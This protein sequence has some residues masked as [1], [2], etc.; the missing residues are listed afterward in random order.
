MSWPTPGAS[1]RS[2]RGPTPAS[3]AGSAPSTPRPSRRRPRWEWPIRDLL[4]DRGW[5]SAWLLHQ[6]LGRRLCHHYVASRVK[7]LDVSGYPDL[8][9]FLFPPVRDP[10]GRVL[11]EWSS[12]YYPEHAPRE[13]ETG[14]AAAGRL[15]EAAAPPGRPVVWEPV[16][17]HVAA[18]L[19]ALELTATPGADPGHRIRTEEDLTGSWF[20]TLR[21]LAGT[22]AAELPEALT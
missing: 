8:L 20:R 21:R 12:P 10:S 11:A 4:A 13:W 18:A 5:W 15:I 3:A 6:L 19:S 7:A 9:A 22:D 2:C 1:S 17:R 14:Q 16:I